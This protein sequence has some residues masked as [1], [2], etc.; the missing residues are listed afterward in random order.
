M[1]RTTSVPGQ[2]VNSISEGRRLIALPKPERKDRFIEWHDVTG[3]DNDDEY[4]Q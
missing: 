1:E 4:L 3:G 2:I